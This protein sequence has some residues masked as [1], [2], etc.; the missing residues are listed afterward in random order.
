MIK[1]RTI[2]TYS[3]EPGALKGAV[4]EGVRAGLKRLGQIWHRTILPR[5]FEL[6]AY[7]RYAPVYRKRSASTRKK[8]GH[9]RPMDY[10]GKLPALAKGFAMIR[11]STRRVKVDLI[12]LRSMRLGGPPRFPD[13]K[14]ELTAVSAR[15]HD[16]MGAELQRGLTDYLNSVRRPAVK[17]FG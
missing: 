6:G 2:I 14:A 13:Y 16:E 1:L 3:V 10:T 9:A 7:S 12:G 5:H 4:K 11:A 17:S 15:E 8:K